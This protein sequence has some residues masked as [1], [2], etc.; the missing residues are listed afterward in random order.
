MEVAVVKASSKS[1]EAVVSAMRNVYF[2]AQQHLPSS[3]VPDLNSLCIT[4]GVTK[5]N[6]L[7][8]DGHTTYEHNTSIQDFQDCIV[9]VIENEVLEKVSKS[10]KFSIMIDESTDI[11]VK[12]NMI[13]YVRVLEYDSCGNATPQTYFLGLSELYRA[14]AEGIY[15]KVVD[16]LKNKGIDLLNLCSVS[17]DGASV[18]VGNKSGVVTKLKNSVPGVLATHCIAHRLALSCCTGADTIPYLVKY[19]EILNSVY[20]F[21][22]NSPKN[23]ATL[24]AIQSV[25]DEQDKKSK[26]KKFREVFHTRWLSFEGSV[27]A[28]LKNYSSLVSVFLEETSGKALSLYKPI[29]C[30]KFLYVSHFLADCLKPLVI[31][32]KSYQ[33]ENINYAEVTPLLTTT[34][35]TLEELRDSKSGEML[36]KFLNSAPAEPKLDADGLYTFQFGPHTI[37]DGGNQRVEAEKVCTQ[38]ITNMVKSLN[39]R[40]SDNQDSAILTALSNFFNPLISEGGLEKDLETVNDYLGSFGLEGTKHE[41]KS[42]V[43]FSRASHGKGNKTVTDIPSVCNLALRNKE[44]FPASAEAAERLLVAPVSTASCERGFSQQNLIKTRLRNSLK[45]ENLENLMTIAINGS[46]MDKFDFG[47]AFA[48]WAKKKNRRILSE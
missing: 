23:T 5:L 4:Q 1:E 37:R 22:R 34:V 11:S 48:I 26:E 44:S 43:K 7:K 15:S 30:Y 21:F 39:D 45:V 17:T 10:K 3:V 13:C 18:M 12:Q 6:D 24:S 38:F 2:A 19:Q 27:D 47:K 42:F 36:G 28:I 33:K 8:V 32:S 29:T 41:L 20:K 46:D 25:I 16:M 40:F 14:N 35:E 31:L 9:S